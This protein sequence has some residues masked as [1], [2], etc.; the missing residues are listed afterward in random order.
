MC[1]QVLAPNDD[2]NKSQSSND[3]FPTAMHIAAYTLLVEVSLLLIF[4]MLENSAT[5]SMTLILCDSTRFPEWK[6][7]GTL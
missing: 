5:F 7:C 6:S 4:K 2:V 1:V 3:T